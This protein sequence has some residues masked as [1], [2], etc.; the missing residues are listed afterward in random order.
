MN[1]IFL[2][3]LFLNSDILKS[4]IEDGGVKCK[5]LSR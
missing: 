4:D 5:L 1:V 2:L 3:H